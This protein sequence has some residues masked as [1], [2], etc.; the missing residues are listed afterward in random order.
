[1]TTKY[2]WASGG[3]TTNYT[4]FVDATDEAPAL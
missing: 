4:N 1:M 2:I 3:V